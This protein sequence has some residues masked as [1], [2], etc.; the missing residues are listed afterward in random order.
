MVPKK[1]KKEL[2]VELD[3]N[4]SDEDEPPELPKLSS[5]KHVADWILVVSSLLQWHQWM[6]QLTI[7]KAQVRKSE[8]AVQWLVRQV[9]QV[10]PRQQGMGTNTI[11]THLVLHLFEDM[12]D[13]G[14]PENVNSAYAESAHI[15]LAK[16]TS[17]NTQKRAVSFTKQAG[18]RY[19]ENLV[20]SLASAD[21]SRDTLR[22]YS[23]AGQRIPSPDLNAT[24]ETLT[25]G[26]LAGRQFNITWPI[27]ND[28]ASFNWHRKGPS[29]DAGKDRLP[30]HITQ[31]LA[32]HCL[33][34][35]HNGKLL[36]ATEFISRKRHGYR[37]HPNIYDGTSWND[38]A[39][40]KWHDFVDPIPAL[41]HAFVDLRDLPV[42]T[43]ISIPDTDQI[44]IEE[45]GVYALVHS[46]AAVDKRET[47]FSNSM[48]G[49][50]TVYQH[51][52]SSDAP[53]LYL[54]DV[55]CIDSP[56]IGIPDVGCSQRDLN[57]L[58]LIR[59]KV[60]WPKAWDSMIQ[61][62]FEARNNPSIEPQWEKKNRNSVDPDVLEEDQPSRIRATKKHRR[63]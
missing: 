16:V 55:E 4:S 39:M 36:C 27:G 51:S 25:R 52:P 28:D 29:D 34:H 14:V 23:A 8:F 63:K 20:V 21:M 60:D 44:P 1:R 42:G 38:H 3:C 37:A 50:Y 10:S 9:A 54:V 17:R 45:A 18:H 47:D 35:T 53:S 24:S 41:I 61:S 30:L 58:F 59:R 22:K 6:N 11:K 15:P 49:R 5:D 57:Y 40:V 62:C 43:K 12:L 31:H 7:A 26:R 2:V 56:T 13:H 33:P 46:F 48:I 32:E 19:I